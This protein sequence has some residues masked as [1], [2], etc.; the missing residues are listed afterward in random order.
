MVDEPGIQAHGE[1]CPEAPI[2][3]RKER[4]RG[5][6][7]CEEDGRS[8]FRGVAVHRWTG[9]FEAHIWEQGKQLYLGSFDTEEKAARAY[10]KAAISFRRSSDILNFPVEDYEQERPYLEQVT[11]EELVTELRRTSAGFSR[12]TCHYRGV[13]WRSSTGRWEARIGRLLGRK[14]TYLGTFKSGEEAARAYDQAAIVCRGRNAI[15]NFDLQ[16]YEEEIQRVEAATPEEREAMERRIATRSVCAGAIQRKRSLSRGPADARRGDT[17]QAGSSEGPSSMHVPDQRLEG[18]PQ[19][20]DGWDPLQRDGGRIQHNVSPSGDIFVPECN[21]VDFAR[22]ESGMQQIAT[23]SESNFSLLEELLESH[24][25]RS[26]QDAARSPLDQMG[27]YLTAYPAPAANVE[28]V[29]PN[30]SRFRGALASILAD[31]AP[32]QEEGPGQWSPGYQSS[33]LRPGFDSGSSWYTSRPCDGVS[34]LGKH[35]LKG[36]PLFA[37]NGSFQLGNVT[38]NKE[39]DRS[40]CIGT[41]VSRRSDNVCLSTEEQ[42][43][44]PFQDQRPRS[45]P[46]RYPASARPVPT[47]G[48]SSAS[49]N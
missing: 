16:D 27:E 42:C 24:L 14:Y 35:I 32:L 40:D 10:D 30:R 28:V 11:K 48:M 4:A 31:S 7:A 17:K 22:L 34:S 13:S 5:P 25:G 26:E 2:V 38:R 46:S 41:D 49:R 12:G 29:S 47:F 33:F 9:R 18:L 37:P 19:S 23:N 15:T 6:R 39:Q 21:R 43:S 45:N 36:N 20:Q 1:T 3:R 8:H 44:W